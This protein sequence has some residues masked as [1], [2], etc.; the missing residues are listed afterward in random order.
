MKSTTVSK[1]TRKHNFQSQNPQSTKEG[2]SGRDEGEESMGWDWP[3]GSLWVSICCYCR[4]VVMLLLSR[5]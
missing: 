2:V 1:D 4:C 3:I 5:C